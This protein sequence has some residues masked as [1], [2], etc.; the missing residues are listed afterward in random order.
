GRVLCCEP[1]PAVAAALAA[2]LRINNLGQAQVVPVAV[3]DADGDGWLAVDASDS[4]QSR[5]AAGGIAVPLRALDSLVAEH[6]LD[7]LDLVKI[8]VEGHEAA[9][10]AGATRT[11]KRLRPALIFESGH[12]TPGDRNRIADLLQ[13]FA[14]DTIAVLH[15]HGALPCASADYRAAA[16]ACAGSEARNVV[17][18]PL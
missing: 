18:L 2:T 8:D 15:H 16:G 4:G 9:V 6:A 7:R 3:S 13:R 5:L 11:L 17:T 12:E 10:L 14:Y 1:N